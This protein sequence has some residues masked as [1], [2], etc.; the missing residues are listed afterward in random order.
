MGFSIKTNTKVAVTEEITEGTYQAP[1]D[2]DFVTVLEDGLEL[3]GTKES[4]ERNILGTGLTKAQPRTANREVSGTV[5]CEFKSGNTEGDA[6]EYGIMV[7]SSL[8]D[9]RSSA[10]SVTSETGHTTTQI[11]IGDA[12]ISNFKV[13]DI[14]L[15]KE[16]GA[17]HLSPITVVDESIGAAFI[18]ILIAGD[19]AFSDNVEIAN[20]TTY[21]AADTGHPT[22]SVTKYIEDNIKTEGLGC[23]TTSMSVEN[24][25]ANQLASW[26]FG[27]Q[28]LD[29]NTSVSALSNSPSYDQSLP[30]VIVE[31]CI[32]K[33]GVKLPVSE[34]NFSVENTVATITSTCSPS[35]KLGSRIS[36]RTISG[37]LTPYIEDDNVDIQDEFDNDTLYSIFGF[38]YNPTAT[39]GEF[40]QV[41]A[42]Y[43]P[44]CSTTELTE[45]DNDGV[46]THSLTFSASGGTDGSVTPMFITFI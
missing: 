31:A 1:A 8:G 21:F 36:E 10:S 35:G 19:S 41:V 20:F 3:N 2:S 26:S 45:S 6:P 29:F 37:S 27:V 11:N 32:Y 4:L 39:A 17:F 7:E 44:N 28:G 46:L 14:A 5:P 12:D 16:A 13:G 18:T 34:M 38:A 9:K 22:F 30:P 33:N 15:I 24:F 42:F 43:M 40:G 25:S 23:R